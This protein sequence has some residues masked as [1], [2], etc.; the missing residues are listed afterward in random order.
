[1][2][3]PLLATDPPA[4][5]P[6]GHPGEREIAGR[7]R[8]LIGVL[9]P[10]ISTRTIGTSREGRPLEVVVLG[11]P[12]SS[13]RRPALLLVGGMDGSNLASTD[14]V[15]ASLAALAREAPELLD[16][17]RVYAIAVAN[18]D[19][20]AAAF[21]TGHP[22][23]TNLREVDADRDGATAEDP[24]RDLDGDGLVTSMRRVAPPG[25]TATH[26]IDADDPR[27][28][29]P[30][31][32]DK[33]D[34]AEIATHEVFIEGADL[35]GDGAIAED[36]TDGVDLDRNFPHRWPEF[37]PDAGPFQ[38]SEPESLAIATF[39]R[40]H[41]E[42][43]SAVVFGRHDVLASFPDTRDMDATGRTPMV[44]LEDD[45]AL[46]RDLSR[47]WK[48]STR[49]EKSANADLAGS[50]VL[51]LANHRGIAAVAANGWS[52]PEPPPPPEG[53]PP[54]PET[55]APDDAAWLRVSDALRGGRGFVAWKAFAH[56]TLGEVE[57]GGFA[58]FFRESPTAAE[59][60][61]LATKSAAFVK[62]LAARRPHVTASP[63]RVERLAD[64]LARLE[65]RVANEGTLPTTTA[66]GARTDV[67]PPV[68]VRLSVAPD[69]VLGG[70]RVEKIERLAPG[71]ARDFT[72]IVRAAKGVDLAA[73]ISGPTFDPIVRS[74]EGASR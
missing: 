58:P 67:V 43:T 24:P 28:V 55:G 35:D 50:L 36:G 53:T 21:A 70:R 22:R 44:Y 71:E 18:P 31:R 69:D 74:A 16:Q 19:A 30:A 37:A 39:V 27:I 3:S 29:R 34:K 20:R 61:E 12:D 4:L 41:P 5:A 54:P 17:I 59:A 32:R 63:L 47:L 1:M 14:Q 56:P 10:R 2:Q 6:A 68:V 42:I 45:H 49:I 11:D 66:M 33:V 51:W 57:I 52:R 65:L 46:Y 9:G 7:V 62:A 8:D 25:R 40:A 23:R 38:L 48:E 26:V 13:R 72:W 60:A 64:G 73:T 15:L